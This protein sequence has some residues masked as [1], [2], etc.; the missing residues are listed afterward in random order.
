MNLKTIQSEVIEDLKKDYIKEW[1]EDSQE[2]LEDLVKRTID[3]TQEWISEKDNPAP[4][5]VHLLVSIN[6]ENLSGI[7]CH[8]DPQGVWKDVYGKKL[9]DQGFVKYYRYPVIDTD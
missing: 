5:G 7:L 9:I 8:K 3:K 6:G 4:I 2:I 1:I